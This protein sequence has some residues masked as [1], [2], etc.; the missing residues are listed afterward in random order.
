ME[1]KKEKKGSSITSAGDKGTF[2]LGQ[3]SNENI[4]TV[5]PADI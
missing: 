3:K 2:H 5:K 1:V 4:N